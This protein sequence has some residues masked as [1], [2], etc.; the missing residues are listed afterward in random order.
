MENKVKKNNNQ[1][2]C[3]RTRIFSTDGYQLLIT[4]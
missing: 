3:K 4:Q 2:T 1:K